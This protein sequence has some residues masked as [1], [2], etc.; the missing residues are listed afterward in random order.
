MDVIWSYAIGEAVLQMDTAAIV[1]L[2]ETAIAFQFEE[3]M[4]SMNNQVT[5]LCSILLRLARL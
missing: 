2:N 4:Q 5:L 1:G 3:D